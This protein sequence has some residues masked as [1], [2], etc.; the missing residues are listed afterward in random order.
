MSATAH[1]QSRGQLQLPAFTALADKA[2]ESVVVSLDSA[3]LAMAGRFLNARDPDEASAK[4]VISRLTGI[5]VRSYRFA[6]DFVYPRAEMETL[7]RQLTAPGWNR[8]VQTRNRDEPAD[9]D[10]YVLVEK[11]RAMGLAVIAIEP[12]ELTVVN[13]VGSIE[14]SELHEIEGR[15]GVPK[16][17][18]R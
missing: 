4:R 5:Y 7:R 16:V 18:G 1:A 17:S 6:E 10:I 9:V 12:R 15:F 2:S 11:G 13:I 8:I 3:L 14:L